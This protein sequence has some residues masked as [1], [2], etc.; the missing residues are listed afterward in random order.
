MH[1]EIGK[2]EGGLAALNALL[3]A[4]LTQLEQRLLIKFGALL[5]AAVVLPAA[6]AKLG[7]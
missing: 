7:V 3:A 2:L 4:S 1:A 6:L 5:S